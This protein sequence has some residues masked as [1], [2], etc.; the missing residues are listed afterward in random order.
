M[1]KLKLDLEALSVQSFEPAPRTRS[2]G[3]VLGRE[4]DFQ[5]SCACEP[6]IDYIIDTCALTCYTGCGSGCA[7]RCPKYCM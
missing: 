3:T 5:G 2:R 6:S 4:T 7:T 1:N